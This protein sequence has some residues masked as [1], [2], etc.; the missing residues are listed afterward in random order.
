M[1]A[2][3]PESVTIPIV[4][5]RAAS[6]I[7]CVRLRDAIKIGG[8]EVASYRPATL[9]KESVPAHVTC[10]PVRDGLVFQLA[11]GVTELFVPWSN[12]LSVEREKRS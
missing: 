11:D 4:T 10:E 12:V 9:T 2:P 7:V 8:H 3:A 5:I 6:S 1:T